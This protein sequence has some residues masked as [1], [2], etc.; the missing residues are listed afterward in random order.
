MSDTSACGSLAC[1]TAAEARADQLAPTHKSGTLTD[2]KAVVLFSVAEQR[3]VEL[4]GAAAFSTSTSSRLA[5]AKFA[6]EHLRLEASSY[7]HA[8]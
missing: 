1:S 8:A 2:K 6:L 3:S 7:L 4:L 5:P